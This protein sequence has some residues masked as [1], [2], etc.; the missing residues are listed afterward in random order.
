MLRSPLQLLSAHRAQTTAVVLV[1]AVALWLVAAVPAA[2]IQLQTGADHWFEQFVPV[3]YIDPG[4]DE[5]TL[6]TMV[7]EIDDWDGVAGVEHH[8]SSRAYERIGD[9]IGDDELASMGVTEA[10]VPELLIIEP[11]LWKPGQIEL[12]A[13]AE[14]LEERQEVV[15]VDVPDARS[16]EW[17]DDARWMVAALGATALIALIAALAVVVNF[18]RMLSRRERREHHLLEVFGAKPRVLR[19]PALWRGLVVGASA[20][21]A[22]AVGFVGWSLLL[23]RVVVGLAGIGAMSALDSALWAGA[24]FVVALLLGAVAGWIGGQPPA[25]GSKNSM[26][27]W[28]KEKQ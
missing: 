18:L 3:V 21:T 22:A 13:R 7:E 12:L 16:L 25:D 6:V 23:D 1:M 20:G 19:F 28:P 14:A 27:E 24:L 5:Q 15:A 10:M 2:L 9:V 11:V 8:D 26:L 4:A 17:M